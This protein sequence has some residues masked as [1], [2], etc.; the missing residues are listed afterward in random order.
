M[1]IEDTEVVTWAQKEQPW[2][3]MDGK[4]WGLWR[5]KTILCSLQVL[6]VDLCKGT[7]LLS[8]S[9]WVQIPCTPTTNSPL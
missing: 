4:S 1:R 2:E 5:D 9:I 3:E 6:L 7:F 8:V